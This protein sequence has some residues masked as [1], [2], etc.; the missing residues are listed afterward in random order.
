MGDNELK[1]RIEGKEDE[2]RATSFA[3]F[4]LESIKGLRGVERVHGA[5]DAKE[6]WIIEKI[7]MNSPATVT[8]R[9]ST[10]EGRVAAYGWVRG[11]RAMEVGK[12][13]PNGWD[14]K[15][16]EAA[17][18]ALLLLADGL[19]SVT[20][21][22]GDDAFTPSLTAVSVINGHFERKASI[23]HKEMTTLVGLLDALNYHDR[24][25][26]RF[27]IF[28][29]LTD[30]PIH[31]VFQP[32]DI[33]IIAELVKSSTT[34]L[35]VYGLADYGKKGRPTLIE[36]KQYFQ[37]PSQEESDAAYARIK[38]RPIDVANGEDTVDYVLRVR[39]DE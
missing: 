2:L 30:E 10:Q 25:H 33:P 21:S 4:L 27:V 7:E 14:D 37:L 38:T 31:C 15:T 1:I 26:P 13:I 17:R 16:L 3:E 6:S 36:V 8:L 24:E 11:L 23:P 29:P 32:Q 5:A 39:S 18:S 35:S 20:L 22:I 28:D 9:P 34:R 12:T 19:Y